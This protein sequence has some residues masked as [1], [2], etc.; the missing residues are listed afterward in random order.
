M[1]V[2]FYRHEQIQIKK[3]KKKQKERKNERKWT[4]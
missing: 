1:S 2:V 4:R 3:E